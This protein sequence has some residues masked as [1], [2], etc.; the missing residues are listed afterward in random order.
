MSINK[1]NSEGYYDPTTY[2]ALKNIAKEE[3]QKA[4]MPIVFICSPF[5]GD[6]DCNISKAQGYSRFAISKGYIPFAP[7]LLFPQFLNDDD[8][9]QRELGLF[10]GMVFMSK[11]REVW[12]FGKNITKGMSSEINKAKQKSIPIRYFTDRC[13]EVKKH[14]NICS[15]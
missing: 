6:V 5:A 14:E 12:V 7:H 1:F 9:S 15:K 3:K 2:E 8:K 4:Y 11:C 10:C 13:E